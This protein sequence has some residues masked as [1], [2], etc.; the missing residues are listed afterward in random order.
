M[1]P[2][3]YK[4]SKHIDGETG[5]R[6]HCAYSK[7]E[8]LEMHNHEYYEFFLTVSGEATHTVNGKTSTLPEGSLVFIRPRDIHLYTKTTSDEY[9][10]ANLAFSKDVLDSLLPY[11]SDVVDT[12]ALLSSDAPPAVF[13]SRGEKDSLFSLLNSTNNADFKNDLQKKLYFKKV[14]FELFTSYFASVIPSSS[15]IPA[16]LYRAVEK[17]RSPDNFLL[18][19]ARFRTL[20]KRSDEHICRS[21]KKHYG[22]TPTELISEI[23]LNYLANMLITT[24]LSITDLG[25]EC[26]FENASWF[27]ASFK[28]K[29]GMTPKEFRKKHKPKL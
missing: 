13:L 1:I 3:L 6:Y 20:C 8:L 15:D 27:Y 22:L 9:I 28:R 18:G 12:G 24:N 25:Y 2:V 5:F 10:F 21:L 23:K 19:V 7:T 14:L 16:W 26:G 29:Y 4:E 17:M 11:I